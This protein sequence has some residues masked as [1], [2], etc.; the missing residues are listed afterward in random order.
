MAGVEA[1]HASRVDRGDRPGQPCGR[2]ACGIRARSAESHRDLPGEGDRTGDAH[3]RSALVASLPG[4]GVDQDRGRRAVEIYCDT[5][6]GLERKVLA[7]YQGWLACPNDGAP[8]GNWVH[9]FNGTVPDAP[10]A[11]F[12]VWP[13]TSELTPGEALPDRDDAP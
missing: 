3:A 6:S 5:G 13:D 9:W 10:H 11:T 8:P 7:G 4:V 2:R 12:D 1:P